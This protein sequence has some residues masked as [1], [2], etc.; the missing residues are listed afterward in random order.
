MHRLLMKFLRWWLVLLLV[1]ELITLTHYFTEWLTRTWISYS[2]YKTEQLELF[3]VLDV[4]TYLLHGNFITCI[5]YP[6]D[7]RSSFNCQLCDFDHECWTSHNTLHTTFIPTTAN[8]LFI[9]SRPAD[10]T[11]LQDC[12]WRWSL[13]G[14]CTSSV[15][16]FTKLSGRLVLAFL[17]VTI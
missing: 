12:V 8:A 5:G 15:E 11:L 2:V 17:L 4:S 14:C 1:L 13:F 16:Q 3:V 10:C 7:P 6:C 9:D